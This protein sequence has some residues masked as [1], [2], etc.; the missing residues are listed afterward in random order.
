MGY[1]L[2]FKVLFFSCII[3]RKTFANKQL[4]SGQ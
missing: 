1:R 3:Y 2:S 4:N